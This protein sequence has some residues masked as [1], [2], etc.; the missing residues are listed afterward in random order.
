MP[1]VDGETAFEEILR[2]EPGAR[3]ILM[4]GYNEQEA[5]VCFAGKGL[6]GF[7][8][9]PFRLLQLIG[10]VRDVVEAR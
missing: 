7:V 2:L 3:V 10:R 4:S 1:R 6:A 8:H 5:A 9:K